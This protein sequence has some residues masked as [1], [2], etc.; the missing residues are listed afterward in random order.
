MHQEK[1]NSTPSDFPST[2]EQVNIRRTSVK[3]FAHIVDILGNPAES[4]RES[5]SCQ[6]RHVQLLLLYSIW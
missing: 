6:H 2:P 5:P 3:D 1:T 4:R